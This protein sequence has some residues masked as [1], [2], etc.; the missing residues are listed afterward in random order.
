MW[1]NVFL[2]VLR[3]VCDAAPMLLRAAKPS[4]F[5]S[6]RGLLQPFL[7]C[8]FPLLPDWK[9]AQIAP[10]FHYSSPVCHRV[11]DMKTSCR[12]CLQGLAAWVNVA[13][14]ALCTR[15]VRVWAV[16]VENDRWG[17]LPGLYI[18][19]RERK[20]FLSCTHMYTHMYMNTNS[21]KLLFH[22]GLRL[23]FHENWFC[24]DCVFRWKH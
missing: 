2:R 7:S 22:L 23:C 1:A 16:P 15:R 12:S 8:L 14:T 5:A 18:R 10:C 11:S 4:D 3:P 9:M 24:W 19:D 20:F 17:F 13:A 21:F 6:G